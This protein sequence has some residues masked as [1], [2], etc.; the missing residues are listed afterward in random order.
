MS[1]ESKN[2]YTF[3]DP[4]GTQSTS[5]NTGGGFNIPID[6]IKDIGGIPLPKDNEMSKWFVVLAVII[7]VGVLWFVGSWINDEMKFK[8]EQIRTCNESF[9]NLNIQYI[10]K[11]Q[12]VY[13]LK[14]DKE[15]KK[16]DQGEQPV[17]NQ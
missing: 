4:E 11:D 1:N 13:N 14:S 5:T 6:V 3:E 7:A 8:N 16:A 9:Q 17:E 12:E 10:L 15:M 2:L